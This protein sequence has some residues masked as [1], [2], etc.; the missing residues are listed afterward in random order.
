MSIAKMVSRLLESITPP[1][2]GRED[3]PHHLQA[4]AVKAG[5]EGL[6]NALIKTHHITSSKK[7]ARIKKASDQ[8]H[9]VL[10]R[11]GG[12]P[13]QMYV[14]GEEQHVK[15]WVALVKVCLS[16]KS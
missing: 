4:M 1:R 2:A 6:Y 8:T 9:F 10:L 5:S 3:S 12:S 14:E 16:L 11:R 15:D 7:V 13:G